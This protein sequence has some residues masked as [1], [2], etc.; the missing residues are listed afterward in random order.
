MATSATAA[1]VVVTSPNYPAFSVNQFTVVT[2][3]TPLQLAN[4]PIPDGIL[5]HMIMDKNQSGT[6]Y[7]ANSS[8]NTA[9]AA[10]RWELKKGD[11]LSL[12]ITNLDLIWIDASSNGR[13]IVVIHE[14]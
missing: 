13:S 1:N 9:N 10:K 6:V 7:V 14:G 8:A 11:T 12:R 2:S 4:T 3:G 5:V